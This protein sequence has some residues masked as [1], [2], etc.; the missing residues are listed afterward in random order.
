MTI[1]EDIYADIVTQIGSISSVGLAIEPGTTDH[2][3]SDQLSAGKHVSEILIGED[4]PVSSERT[5]S[6]I[7]KEFDV[8][9]V[10]IMAPSTYASVK[11]FVVAEAIYASVVAL[12]GNM[13]TNDGTWGGH[14]MRTIDDGGG[15]AAFDPET[16]HR[17]TAVYFTVRYRH[18]H[19]SLE[20]PS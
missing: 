4:R 5:T 1:R 20:E 2:E 18:P 7:E 11:P 6:V 3:I 10:V 17:F 15:G 19:G 14:A 16:N 8:A 12:Y 13:A 9:V